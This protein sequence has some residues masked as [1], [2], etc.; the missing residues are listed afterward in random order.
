MLLAERAKEG[1]AIVG[2]ACIDE[3]DGPGTAQQECVRIGQLELRNLDP[4]GPRRR[5]ETRAFRSRARAR[6]RPPSR[7]PRTDRG[8]ERSTGSRGRRSSLLDDLAGHPA[9]HTPPLSVAWPFGTPVSVACFSSSAN[10]SFVSFVS[11]AT[12]FQGNSLLMCQS[13]LATN[14]TLPAVMRTSNSSS[15]RAE[16]VVERP[17][18]TT[19]PRANPSVVRMVP[20]LRGGGRGSRAALGP[21]SRPPSSHAAYRGGDLNMALFRAVCRLAG[22]PLDRFTPRRPSSTGSHRLWCIDPEQTEAE[23]HDAGRRVCEGEA[24]ATNLGRLGTEHRTRFVERGEAG[25]EAEGKR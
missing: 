20:F 6:R 19:I 21:Q 9:E 22:D 4:R 24:R 5:D 2:A 12:S 3:R 10:F 23:G 14:I 1:L 11:P 15:A 25:R 18:S 8:F 7:E 13:P 16:P 17:A